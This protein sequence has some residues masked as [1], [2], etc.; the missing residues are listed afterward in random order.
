MKKDSNN[1]PQR[2]RSRILLILTSLYGLLYLIFIIISFIPSSEGSPVSGTVPFDPFDFEQIVVKLFFVLFLVGY[3]IL[4][5][6]E[7]LA[8]LIFVI[9][10]I[11]MWYLGFFVAQ[12]DRGAS[13]IMG[14][15]LFVLAILLIISWYRKRAAGSSP[16]SMG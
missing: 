3:F 4:W 2:R 11:G 7:G 6:N 10:W 5:K 8:G 16:S 12:H 9:W 13:V 15:P 1:Q 14:F